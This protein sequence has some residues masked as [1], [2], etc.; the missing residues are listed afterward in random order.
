MSHRDVTHLSHALRRAWFDD[1]TEG[2]ILQWVDAG[3][4]GFADPIDEAV[5]C[6]I[7]HP[8]GQWYAADLSMLKPAIIH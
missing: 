2:E 6:L 4:E 8:S 7:K 3:N 5:A 1:G